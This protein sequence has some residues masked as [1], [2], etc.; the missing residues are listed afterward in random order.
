M[1]QIFTASEFRASTG[2]HFAILLCEDDGRQLPLYWPNLFA[3]T[4]LRARSLATN[5]ILRVLRNLGLLYQ[6]AA[7]NEIDLDQTL[8]HGGF[9]SLSQ[10]ELLAND[11][12]YAKRYLIARETLLGRKPVVNLESVRRREED[13]VRYAVSAGEAGNRIAD[14]ARYL[15]W[16]A[17]RRVGLIKDTNEALLFKALS[18]SA[19]SQLRGL[20]PVKRT[21][22][23]D[24]A[25]TGLLPA[26]RN[27]LLAAIRPDSASN[28]F[29]GGFHRLRNYLYLSLLY[30]VGHR[31]GESLQM[32]VED[33]DIHGRLV[34]IHRSADDADDPRS[35]QPRTKTLARTVP[36]SAELAEELYDY[37]DGVWSRFPVLQR[38]HGYLWTSSSGTPIALS[39]VNSMF[40][41]LRRSVQGLPRDLTPHVFR[42]DWNE[43]FSEAVDALPPEKRLAEA[44]EV[45]VRCQ[46]MGWESNSNMAARYTQRFIREK[47]AEIA[48]KM[49]SAAGKSSIR[50][51]R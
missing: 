4:Q 2:E 33:I 28:P 21:G 19:I 16:H 12:R 48:E 44:K 41:H 18:D 35:V 13:P 29:R 15:A 49:A 51:Q 46:M 5:T 8:V 1:N 43:R 31:R 27:L 9:L 10:V 36:I 34:R 17:E 50:R 30:R 6:W 32:K 39:T 37:I 23:S 11:L 25:R 38:K 47:A 24:A 14:V 22:D 42:H 40:R 20:K 45:A 26:E 3:S 7:L